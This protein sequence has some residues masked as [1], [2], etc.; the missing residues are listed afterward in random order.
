R[1]SILVVEDEAEVR[2]TAVVFLSGLGY[3]VFQAQDGATAL[4]LIESGLVVDLLFTDVIMP[5]TVRSG[6]LVKHARQKLPRL[7]VLFTS[8]YPEG[9]LARDGKL[10]AHIRLL[11]KPYGGEALAREIAQML[12]P[13]RVGEGE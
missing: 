1:G 11:K 13:E 6:E 3:T 10:E 9:E 7:Q 4:A 8:G 12:E 2:E 5:G